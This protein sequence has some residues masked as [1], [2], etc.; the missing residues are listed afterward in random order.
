MMEGNNEAHA[1]KPVS[2]NKML[3]CSI[4]NCLM[5][6]VTWQAG[7]DRVWRWR[8]VSRPHP[9]TGPDWSP[10]SH[11]HHNTIIRL[12]TDKC[13]AKFWNYKKYSILFRIKHSSQS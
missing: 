3:E 9:H 7:S 13:Q 8:G 1:I 4:E 12:K 11:R 10:P 2:G 5:L 6:V